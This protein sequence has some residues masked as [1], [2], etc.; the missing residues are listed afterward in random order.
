MAAVCLPA[1]NK[2][3][4]IN[5]SL[6]KDI[7]TQPYDSTQTTYVKPRSAV[8]AE[9]SQRRWHQRAGKRHSWRYERSTDHRISQSCRWYDA[10]CSDSGCQQ[11]QRKQHRRAFRRRT[12]EYHRAT[13]QRGSLFRDL[14]ASVETTTRE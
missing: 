10:G 2:S 14:P 3:A 6:W 13:A 4:G 7:C 8:Y 9:P 12:S 11:Y 5:L 1:Q